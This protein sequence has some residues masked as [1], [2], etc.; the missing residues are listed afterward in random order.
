MRIDPVLCQK[1]LIAVEN[2]P[3]AGSGQFL[4]ITVDGYDANAIANHVKYLWETEMISGVEVT[5]L[6]SPCTPEIAVTDITPAGR[7]FLD[8]REPDPPR[9]KIGF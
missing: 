6:Q 8:E 9:R 2:D 7:S 1:I 4:N 3:D 5:H